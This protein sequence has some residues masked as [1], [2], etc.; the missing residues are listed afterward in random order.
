MCLAWL[1]HARS[2]G[3]GGSKLQASNRIPGFTERHVLNLAYIRP[4]V[5]AALPRLLLHPLNFLMW[6]MTPSS[7]GLKP[8][9]GFQRGQGGGIHLPFKGRQAATAPHRTA[10]VQGLAGGR[11]RVAEID[12]VV[13]K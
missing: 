5:K 3:E 12:N 7:G 6:E 11:S 8:Q 2:H 4:V 10:A 9:V 1:H 13:E